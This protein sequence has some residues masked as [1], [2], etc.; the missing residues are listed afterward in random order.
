MKQAL[1]VSVRHAVMRGPLDKTLVQRTPGI[2]IAVDLN[3]HAG[4]G[5]VTS[6][7]NRVVL[8]SECMRKARPLVPVAGDDKLH[9][10][11]VFAH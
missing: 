2:P 9:R 8:K 3:R 4:I 7:R 11:P 10:L 5:I 1:N 6:R